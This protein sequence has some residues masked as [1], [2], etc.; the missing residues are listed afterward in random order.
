LPSPLSIEAAKR[1]P[2]IL[3]R[4][5]SVA[6]VLI[7]AAKPFGSR[8]PDPG[9]NGQPFP[10]VCFQRELPFFWRLRTNAQRL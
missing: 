5:D 8:Q 4:P 2:S 10:F 7:G 6:F 1:N 9:C 3:P